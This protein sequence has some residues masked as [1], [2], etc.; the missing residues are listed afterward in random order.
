MLVLSMANFRKSLD[1]Y[2]IILIAVLG[3]FLSIKRLDYSQNEDMGI[4]L[5]D[6]RALD[7]FKKAVKEAKPEMIINKS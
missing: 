7:S 5:W 4:F 1:T 3:L 2:F 6:V